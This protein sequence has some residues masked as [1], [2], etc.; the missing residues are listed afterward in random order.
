MKLLHAYSEFPPVKS[1]VL[2]L[3]LFGFAETQRNVGNTGKKESK[4]V[5]IGLRVANEPWRFGE[6]GKQLRGF[7]SQNIGAAVTQCGSIDTE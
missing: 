6:E 1:Q 7:W 5:F 2:I 4:F 3:C